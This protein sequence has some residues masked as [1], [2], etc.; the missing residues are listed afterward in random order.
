MSILF[1]PYR[2]GAMEIKNRFVRSATYFGLSDEDGYVGERSVELMRTL[3]RNEVGLIVTG[4][5]F[6]ARSGQVFADMNGI[7][8]DMTVDPFGEPIGT[9]VTSGGDAGMRELFSS[10]LSNVPRTEVQ[11]GD[12]WTAVEKMP[13]NG[14]GDG[15]SLGEVSVTVTFEVLGFKKHAGRD[16]MVIGLEGEMD[17]PAGDS[18][19][20][21]GAVLNMEVAMKGV[22]FFDYERGQM[23]RT[24]MDVDIEAGAVLKLPAALL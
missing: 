19:R 15:M 9:P 20:T 5:A 22:I 12:T 18:L 17:G 2:I 24:A 23:V 7:T 21:I 16:C 6:V 3:A 4:Y 10:H 13:V 11:V 1:E 8:V 14:M